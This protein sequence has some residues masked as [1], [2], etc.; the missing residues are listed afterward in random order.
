MMRVA[1]D[2]PT[3]LVPYI[4]LSTFRTL[5][6]DTAVDQGLCG[7]LCSVSVHFI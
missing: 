1:C 3:K 6:D 5:E 7:A 4:M 2:V